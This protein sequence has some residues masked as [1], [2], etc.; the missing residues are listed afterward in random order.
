M[1]IE[2]ATGLTTT[3]I[4]SVTVENVPE[5]PTIT[6]LPDT[7]SVSEADVGSTAI[8]TVSS[9]DPEDDVV[10]YSLTQA[11]DTG[12]FYIHATCKT[13]HNPIKVMPKI[14]FEQ[15]QKCCAYGLYVKE[16]LCSR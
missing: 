7:V 14:V 2:D 1:T 5:P 10:I 16:T 4:L 15:I 3:A 12:K 8:F 11:P 6:N 9:T 13:Y